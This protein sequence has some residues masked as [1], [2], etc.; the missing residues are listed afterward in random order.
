MEG[1]RHAPLYFTI[2]IIPPNRAPWGELPG[3]LLGEEVAFP[4]DM[5]I[6]LPDR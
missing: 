1:L 6:D 5:V 2:K 3:R 4:Y